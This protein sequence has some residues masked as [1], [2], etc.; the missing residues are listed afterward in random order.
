MMDDIVEFIRTHAAKDRLDRQVSAQWYQA[1][2]DILE[3]HEQWPVLIHHKPEPMQIENVT[4]FTTVRYTLIENIEWGTRKSYVARFG[5]QA[6]TTPIL[7]AYAKIWAWHSD[8]NP[9]WA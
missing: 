3:V 5:E 7:K 8:Y 2:L 4:D 9:D 6:P 1:L